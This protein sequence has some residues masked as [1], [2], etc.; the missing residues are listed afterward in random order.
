VWILDAVESGSR[1]R[2]DFSF[3]AHLLGVISDDKLK[4]LVSRLIVQLEILG[5]TP[6]FELDN[7]RNV[8]GTA[9]QRLHR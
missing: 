1:D 7:M 8:V 5:T 4:S 2:F 9:K 3:P 6:A